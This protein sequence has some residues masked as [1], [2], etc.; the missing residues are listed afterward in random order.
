MIAT[1]HQPRRERE[2][3]IGDSR[4]VSVTRLGGPVPSW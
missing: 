2:L 3:T 4:Q 1:D